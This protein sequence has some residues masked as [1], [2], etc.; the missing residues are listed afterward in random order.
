MNVGLYQVD[1]ASK[2]LLKALCARSS[3]KVREPEH[4]ECKL[5]EMWLNSTINLKMCSHE[6]VVMS[7]GPNKLRNLI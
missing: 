1:I 7:M 4:L 6:T 3:S 5:L 2:A